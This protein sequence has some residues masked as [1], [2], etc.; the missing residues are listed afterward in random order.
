MLG[1]LTHR[2]QVSSVAGTRRSV[3][4]LVMCFTL[5]IA[6]HGLV[7]AV[8]SGR[9][10]KATPSPEHAQVVF[11]V[12]LIGRERSGIQKPLTSKSAADQA[13]SATVDDTTDNEDE[14]SLIGAE[15]GLPSSPSPWTV[16]GETT[17][18]RKLDCIYSNPASIWQDH[19]RVCDPDPTSDAEPRDFQSP[20]VKPN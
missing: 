4:N 3:R 6:L 5:S 14:G 13:V 8:F 16:A 17:A 20:P 7:I 1:R 18:A 19:L 9:Q 10:P 12:E 15:T 11:I 2:A